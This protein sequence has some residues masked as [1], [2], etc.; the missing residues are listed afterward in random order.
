MINSIQQN[1]NTTFRLI[2]LCL[3]IKDILSTIVI[4]LSSPEGKEEITT[5]TAT[6]TRTN[7]G[8]IKIVKLKSLFGD[9]V[10]E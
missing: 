6:Y 1:V 8:G 7:N 9:T 5:E 2:A 3:R 4:I 10:S